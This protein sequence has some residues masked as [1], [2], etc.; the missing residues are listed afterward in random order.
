MAHFENLVPRRLFLRAAGMLSAAAFFPSAI[1]RPADDTYLVG[2]TATGAPFSFIDVKTNDLAGAMVEILQ[3]IARDADF[4]IEMQVMPFSSLIPAL[5]AEKIAIISAAMLKTDARAKVVAFSEPVFAYGGGLVVPASE[6]KEYSTLGDLK[7]MAV[8][9]QVGTRFVEQVQSAGA[10]EVR[11]YDNLALILRDVALRRID[12]GYGDAPILAWEL[13]RGHA[14]GVRLVK[15]FRPPYLEEVCIVLRKNEPS[16]LER[17]NA[18]IR[19]T[20]KTE[21]QP[22]LARWNLN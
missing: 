13:S 7:G 19:R 15:S 8:G 18:S 20:R 9:V 1:R 11:S 14:P 16:L 22:I 10:R 2:S 6:S 4:K 17:I 21:I 3:A 12:A 5:L